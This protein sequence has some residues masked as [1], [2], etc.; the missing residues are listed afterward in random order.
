MEHFKDHP[1]VKNIKSDLKKFEFKLEHT[2]AEKVEKIITKMDTKKSTGYDS[3]PPK[4]LKPV[5]SKIST[6]ISIIFNK[7]IDNSIF[8]HNAKLAEVVPLFKKDDNLMMKNYR[9]V[10]ILPSISKILE[11][12]VHEQLVLFLD[13][14]LD[15]NIAAY[16]KGYSCEHVLLSLVESWKKALDLKKHAG[17][18][19]MDLSKAFDCLPHPLIIAKLEA[20]GLSLNSCAFMW[21]YLSGRQQRVKLSGHVSEWRSLTKGV[22]QGSI[23]GPTLFN[24]FVSDLY[25]SIKKASLHNYADDNTISVT[26]PTRREVI[27]TLHHESTEAVKWF[28]DNMM[29]ANASKFQAL[30]VNWKE[31]VTF[32]IGED[33]ITSESHVKL[34]GVILDD[35]LN[36]HQHV[37]SLCKKAGAQL[38]VLQRLS[39]MLDEPSKMLI[40]RS[41]ILSHFTY[42]CLVWH[43]CGVVFS[44]KLEKIQYRALKFVYCDHVSSYDDL[45]KKAGLPT[46]ELARTRMILLHV[47]K[48]V[49][50]LSP[51]FMWDMYTPRCQVYN[52]R[53]NNT[54]TRSHCRTVR[55]GVQSMSQHGAKLWNLLP[56]KLK[57]CDNLKDFKSNLQNWTPSTCKC[58]I[59]S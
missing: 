20:Y 55:Q 46:L 21:S 37:N 45:L 30:M 23:L 8:P 53:N 14:V 22:P 27:R 12:L 31:P 2:N 11:K 5:A 52:L 10:S 41:F 58:S 18:I 19:L 36:F 17:A 50:K 54:L 13:N 59:C 35:K 6:H 4:L 39:N 16:R 51:S 56:E 49:N 7:C 15:P 40:F 44:N 34:L 9:P 57:T 3:I 33:E 26:A 1:S 25:A 38:R 47:F 48:C 29:E 28:K 24:V 43:F 42:C 32:K